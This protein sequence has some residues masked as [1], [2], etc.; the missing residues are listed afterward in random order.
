MQL[1]APLLDGPLVANPGS[2]GVTHLMRARDRRGGG[3]GDCVIQCS[4][5]HRYYTVREVQAAGRGRWHPWQA[6]RKGQQHTAAELQPLRPWPSAGSCSPAACGAPPAPSDSDWASRRAPT[7]T[8]P[9]TAGAVRG[10][11]APRARPAWDAGAKSASFARHSLSRRSSPRLPCLLNTRHA[12]HPSPQDADR[13][14]S[15]VTRIPPE[16]ATLDATPTLGAAT[17][18]PI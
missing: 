5:R 18:S 2:H 13:C 9:K 16:Q 12:A 14:A 4:G 3:G 15:T 10:R 7:R 11:V 8:G 1:E 17:P 6:C